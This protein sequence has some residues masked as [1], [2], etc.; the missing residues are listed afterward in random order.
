MTS[1]YSQRGLAA[2]FR[3]LLLGALCVGAASAAQA[4]N[5][6]YTV[7]TTTNRPGTYT[8]LGATG[9]V[10]ATANTDDAESAA[11]TIPFTFRF[12][13]T[14]FTQFV[15]NTNG[16]IK[17]GATGLTGAA[18]ISY[19][20]ENVGGPVAGADNNLIMPFN[21][22]L[23]A[24]SAGGT[25]YRMALSGTAPNQV[26][27]IQWKNVS[28]KPAPTS[29]MV[30]A[31]LPT[32]Y[33]NFSFQVRL[34]ETSNRIEFV[35]GR[36][37]AGAVANDNFRRVNV[38]IKGSGSAAGQTILGTKA[39]TQ[40]WDQTTFLSA[41]YTANNHNVRG[42]V[43]PDVGRT[44]I[45]TVPVAV[46]VATQ[47]IYGYGKV[48]PATQPVAVQ[49]LVANTGT[50]ALT[51]ITVT[52]T[53]SG[54]NPLPPVT[55]TVAS[56]AV[57]ANSVVT[58]PAFSLPALGANTLTVTSTVANDANS[59]ND[60]RTDVMESTANT[61]SYITPG[62]GPVSAFGFQAG[63]SDSYFG[64]KITLTQAVSIQAV[65]AFFF[66]EPAA[67]GSTAYGVVVDATTGAVLGRSAD[68]VVT[69]ASL[70]QLHNFPLTANA[71]AGDVIVGMATVAAPGAVQFFLMG[72]Q[73]ENPNRTGSYFTG[74]VS[75][76]ATPTPALNNAAQNTNVYK[77]ML[78]AVT[79]A[80]VSCPPPTAITVANITLTT[81]SVRFTGP[82]TGSSYR[83]V[84]VPVGTM[85]TSSSPSVTGA[86]SPITITGL[87]ASTAYN[88]Y[89]QATCIAPDM[90]ILAG[91]VSFTTPC[92]PPI[93]TTF[94]YAQNFDVIA[95]GQDLPCGIN[96]DDANGDGVTWQARNNVPSGV[97]PTTV[98]TR[99]MSPF[100]MVY[101]KNPDDVT[102]ADDWFYLP[103]MRF[104]AAST[105][106]LSFYYRRGL[107]SLPEALEVKYGSMATAISQ[108]HLLWTNSAIVQGNYRLA[109]NASTPAVA[110]ITGATGINRIGFHCISPA[111]QGFLIVDDVTVSAVLATSAALA[112][113]VN[114]YPNPS[115]TGRFTLDIN[116]AN[117]NAGLQVEVSNMLGQQVYAGTARDNFRNSLDFSQLPA[118]IYSLKVRNGGEQFQQQISIVK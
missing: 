97:P 75:T 50:S 21:V 44:Y 106:R 57:G 38:G 74:S 59:T 113:A 40:S 11:Q 55:R 64:A 96:V 6:S 34:Y 93:I 20:Q 102:S 37:T 8:D 47:V 110:D 81:A 24:G 26:L 23:T 94:P 114:L 53:V 28:D 27:T 72:V 19:A 30:A 13:G 105:Y 49:A 36:A 88:V 111:A 92:T 82:P 56:L 16:L 25:E 31:P 80:P 61:T 18:F 107:N 116:G 95:A 78:E 48:A 42:T 98:I 60:T 58:F 91:P 101:G 2:R 103:A 17:L 5:L 69:T 99:T 10:I 86:S 79:G 71:P 54:T 70:N 83:V 51:N 29:A 77:Y 87:M 76:P 33:T 67:V 45:F 12:N 104:Q 89:V 39:S 68:F 109:D 43:L 112:R 46:D 84:Y 32:Q 15:L 108:T 63:A 62:Q 118:G 1:L 14:N 66:N 73:A 117:A 9:M 90:S 22:D 52:L 85:P 115:T 4:Q 65:N 41:A 35:Y 7:S 3:P 100:A